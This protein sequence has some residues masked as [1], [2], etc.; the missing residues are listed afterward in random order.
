MD[1]LECEHGSTGACPNG[2]RQDFDEP[3]APGI[4]ADLQVGCRGVCDAHG[5]E[6]DLGIGGVRSEQPW[7]LCARV[8]AGLAGV[9]PFHLEHGAQQARQRPK[10]ERAGVGLAAGD[11]DVCAF[12][13]GD[14]G[15]F[16]KEATL[17][18]PGGTDNANEAAGMGVEQVL[19]PA[20]L[21]IAAQHQALL[22]AQHHLLGFHAE[23]L[24]RGHGRVG[25]LDVNVFDGPEPGGFLDEA[26]C[27][28]RA[29]DSARRGGRLH[30][31][32]HSD[33]MADG[34]VSAVAR[35]YFAGDHLA[36]VQPDPDLQGDAVTAKHLG[37]KLFGDG[38]DLQC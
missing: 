14:R 22:A 38:V 34:G 12:T 18:Q 24:S 30:A 21:R 28:E 6:Q 35:A 11:D 29:H 7:A 9:E 8:F 13:R 33:G 37:G 4:G 26:G 16:P 2:V 1:I 25:A 36:R 5:L 31:L 32:R 23:Q 3:A 10:R 17:A 15:E 27:G 19:Q 20:H